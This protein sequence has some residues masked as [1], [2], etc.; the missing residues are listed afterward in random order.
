MLFCFI[1]LFRYYHCLYVQFWCYLL[2]EVLC[3]SKQLNKIWACMLVHF[4]FFVFF[5]FICS[6][7]FKNF[8]YNFDAAFECF[9]NLKKKKEGKI[10]VKRAN[11]NLKPMYIARLVHTTLNEAWIYRAKA[12]RNIVRKNLNTRVCTLCERCVVWF[13]NFPHFPFDGLI[14]LNYVFII[15]TI[16]CLL[17][18]IFS[19]RLW[20]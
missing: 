6:Q 16:M 20:W 7:F 17:Y 5:L 15:R 14:K 4:I 2:R 11:A 19:L 9:E 13:I 8:I 3:F 1:E 10:L 12:W 18:T